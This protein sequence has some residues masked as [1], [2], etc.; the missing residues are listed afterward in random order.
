[1]KKFCFFSKHDLQKEKIGCGKYPN[2]IMAIVGFSELKRLN[3]EQFQ[4]LF[5]V[6]EYEQEESPRKYIQ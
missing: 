1:M 3:L 2:A 6:E 5:Q 4:K